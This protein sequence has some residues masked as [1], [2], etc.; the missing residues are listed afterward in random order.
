MPGATLEL[1]IDLEAQHVVE[2]ELRAGVEASDAKGGTAIVM[3]PHTGEILAFANYP[4]FNPNEA[5]LANPD[6][7]AQS[8]RRRTSTS[9]GRPSRS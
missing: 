3:N 4:T 7:G 9:Q 8:S 2:R 6:R 1:T 5:W